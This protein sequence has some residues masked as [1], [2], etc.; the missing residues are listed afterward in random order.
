MVQPNKV[1]FDVRE[2]LDRK[3]CW[4]GHKSGSGFSDKARATLG[5]FASLD[6]F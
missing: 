6:R 5:V 1:D 2:V 4:T 3:N